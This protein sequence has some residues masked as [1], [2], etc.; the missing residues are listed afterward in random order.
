[1]NSL[2]RSNLSNQPQSRMVGI[3]IAS[4]S[5]FNGSWLIGRQCYDRTVHTGK[6]IVQSV[7]QSVSSF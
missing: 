4:E 3:L 2:D 1:M 5:L 6:K 7:C